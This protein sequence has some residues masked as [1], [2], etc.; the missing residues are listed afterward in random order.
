MN[1]TKRPVGKSTTSRESDFS[2]TLKAENPRSRPALIPEWILY[3]MVFGS[4]FSG[5]IYETL[6][7]KQLGRIFGATAYSTSTVLGV[8]FAGMAIGSRYWGNKTNRIANP[9]RAYA[10]LEIGIGIAAL[11]YFVVLPLYRFAYGPIFSLF[12]DIPALMAVTKLLLSAAVLLPPAVLMGGT[13]PMLGQYAVRHR[14][15]LGKKTALLYG[16]NTLGGVSGVLAAGF[17][18]PVVLGYAGSCLLAVSVNLAVGAAV[19]S[20]TGKHTD[21]ASEPATDSSKAV[22]PDFRTTLILSMVGLSGAF[23]LALE[24]LWTRMMAQV[25]QNSVYSFAAILTLFL[26]SLAAGSFLAS[27]AAGRKRTS[28]P[29]MLLVLFIVA[30]LLVAATPVQ[31]VAVTRGVAVMTQAESWGSYIIRVFGLIASV[32]LIPGLAV[33][34]VFPMLIRIAQDHVMQTGRFLGTVISI[35]TVGSVAGSLAAGFFLIDA[36]GA[37]NSIRLVSI[38]YILLALTTGVFLT[39]RRIVASIGPGTAFLFLL[40]SNFDFLPKVHTKPEETVVQVWEGSHATVAVTEIREGLNL[41]VNNSHI[42]GGTHS[43]RQE[44][45]MAQLPLLLHP[46][47]DKVFFLGM[48]TGIT[49]GGALFHPVKRV[50]V[51]EYVPEVAEAARKYFSSYVNGL[52]TDPRV[53]IRMEDGRMLLAS[54]PE[55]YDVVI[56]DLFYPEEAGDLYTIE[57]FRN[58]RDRL[59]PDGFFAQW[60]PM[61]Q[62]SRSEFEMI[63]H[64]MLEVFPQVTMWRGDFLPEQPAVALVGHMQAEPL[65]TSVVSANVMYAAQQ[66][67][68]SDSV[69]DGL[70]YLF[71]TGNLTAAKELFADAPINRD[72]RP[73]LQ[74]S[75][76]SVPYESQTKEQYGQGWLIGRSLLE[77]FEEIRTV[78]PFSVDPFLSPAGT[79]SVEYALTG[80]RLYRNAV[81]GGK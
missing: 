13:I 8:F 27:I 56:G 11:S 33:G 39:R 80:F 58:V 69:F 35:N 1:N 76:P 37:Y 63:A 62:M 49:A 81:T 3:L 45:I 7:L 14:S 72:D 32:F 21:S 18:L 24:V 40:S 29:G 60:L 28:G 50:T 46:D 44:Q 10:F 4:G 79:E 20:R 59:E 52:F 61:Y 17:F 47:P 73:V 6:W 75:V 64:T 5:L 22:S 66:M 31:F 15:E 41:R 51:S 9:L 34:M 30:S 55:M 48:G 77:L 65:D 16:I 53:R 36:F 71:Y 26:F 23:T 70:P 38:G 78:S 57:H 42:V 12:G 2:S 43:A 54:F 68:V 67:N 74:Y 25:L 19:F